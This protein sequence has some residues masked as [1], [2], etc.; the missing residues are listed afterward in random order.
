M[1]SCTDTSSNRIPPAVFA[2]DTPPRCS[3]WSSASN[4]SLFSIQMGGSFTRDH[5][6]GYSGEITSDLPP[7]I[8]AATN[9][10]A[11]DPPLPIQ[12]AT[13][14][15]TTDPPL[16]I[17][18]ATNEMTTDGNN[19]EVG[20]KLQTTTDVWKEVIQEEEE[21]NHPKKSN[22]ETHISHYSVESITSDRSFAFPILT[23]QTDKEGA[24][25]IGNGRVRMS[26]EQRQQP[27]SEPLPQKEESLKPSEPTNSQG[28]PLPDQTTWFSC[29]SNFSCWPCTFSSWKGSFCLS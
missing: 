14:E 26:Q 15:M 25:S 2:P 19:H 16:Q 20:Q 17:Q 3:D 29:F 11:T 8:H 23:G 21:H 18:A 13:N 6:F 10:M 7:R 9:E 22:E 27:M 1:D 5:F 24:D 4:E 28:E 12:A